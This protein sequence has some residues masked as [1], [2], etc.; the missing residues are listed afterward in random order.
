MT[1]VQLIKYLRGT[2]DVLKRYNDANWISD[3]D[4]I[5]STSGYIFI[6]SGGAVFWKSSKQTLIARSIMES[7]FVAL[8]SIRNEAKLVEEF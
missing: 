8:E 1:I 6:F 3:S 2:I 7:E 5:K 4:E